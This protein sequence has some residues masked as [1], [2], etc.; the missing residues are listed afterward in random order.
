MPISF[1]KCNSSQ[2]TNVAVTSSLTH[3][4]WPTSASIHEKNIEVTPLQ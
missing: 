2:L 4:I 3:I 1:N